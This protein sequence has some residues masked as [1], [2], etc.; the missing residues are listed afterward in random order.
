MRNLTLLTDFYEI[1]M[2]YGFFKEKKH[3]EEVVF[4]LFFRRNKLITYSI[5]AGLEQAIEY[6]TNWHFSDDD[7]DYLRS[8]KIFSE[9]FLEYLKNMRFTGS[10]YAV[11]EGEPVFPG[12]PILS[13]RAPLI[14]AQFAETALLNIIN[15]Q[16]LIATKAAK[17]CRAAK[18]G[19][20]MEF[21]LRRA[22]G[23]D[24]GIY[25]ARAAVIGGCSST[26]NVITGQA[27][28]IPVAG[29]MAHSWVMGFDSEYEAFKAYAEVYPD[30]CLLLVDTYDTLKSGVPNAIKV[31]KELKAKGHEP[32]G[33][34]LDSGDFAYLSKKA[35]KMLDEAGFENAKICASGDLDEYSIRSLLGQGAKIDL[36]GVGTKLITSEEM[37]AL[38]GVYK[39]SAVVKKDG[40]VIPK[41]KLSDNAEKITN[42]SI[43]NVYRLFDKDTGMA[44]A[45][46]IT[47]WDEQIDENEPLT[48][49]HPIETWKRTTVKN[50]RA[51]PLLEKIIENGKLVYE[52]PTV[53]DA[54]EFCK[55]ELSSF[56]EEY[57]RID[58]PHVY[59]VDLSEKLHALKT[60]MIAKIRGTDE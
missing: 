39:L 27:F 18:D 35:R 19:I 13:V 23:P 14:Q 45:D 8:Q 55:K 26:S 5:A 49:F 38:G 1:T 47:L 59:K 7:I 15:H 24:A 46:L 37:P 57:L 53:K 22:Q 31:F 34:R 9:E 51:V 25:G 42:P 11:K 28:D 56:W 30:N 50:F 4:D 54:R 3:E 33:I 21:G 58:M 48:I 36:W 2:A 6:L 29:T 43:K 52:F 10:V 16:T 60:E 41:I 12:E 32:K 20:V 44:I 17:I 40:T